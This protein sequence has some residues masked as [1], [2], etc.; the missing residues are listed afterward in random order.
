MFANTPSNSLSRLLLPYINDRKT[1]YGQNLSVGRTG[2]NGTDRK[3]VVIEFSSPNLGVYFHDGDRHSWHLK[4]AIYGSFISN[5]YENMGWEVVRLNYLGDW[6]KEVANLILGW[7]KFGS[8]DLYQQN[9]VKHLADVYSQLKALIKPE[10]EAIQKAR[11]EGTATGL[12]EQGLIGER[13]D[14]CRRMEEGDQTILDLWTGFRTTSI[15]S[16]M[17][18]YARL[19]ISFDEYAGESQASQDVIAEVE[20]QLREKGLYEMEGSSWGIDFQKHGNLKLRG[21]PFTAMR[22]QHGLSTYLL[23]DVATV[24]DRMKKFGP[25]DKM[26]YV[27]SSDQESHFKKVFQTIRL[28]DPEMADKLEL[29]GIGRTGGLE[30]NLV[31]GDILDQAKETM[32]TDPDMV[33]LARRSEENLDILGATSLI[34]QELDKKHGAPS[35]VDTTQMLAP[36]DRN[37]RFLQMGYR[38]LSAEIKASN[39]TGQPLDN[40][41]FSL[42][43]E[44]VYE[45]VLRIMAQFPDAV[46]S[47]FK[48][49]DSAP[50]LN[51]LYRLV[52]AVNKIIEYV[53][54]DDQ[55][56]ADVGVE[57]KVDQ[58]P[59]QSAPDAGPLP[60]A[61]DGGSAAVTGDDALAIEPA[62]AAADGSVAAGGESPVALNGDAPPEAAPPADIAEATQSETGEAPAVTEAEVTVVEGDEA[63]AA[64][65]SGETAT[66]DAAVET[67][68]AQSTE[69]DSAVVTTGDDTVT[70]DDGQPAP[71]TNAIEPIGALDGEVATAATKDELPAAENEAPAAETEVEATEPAHAQE[72]LAAEADATEGPDTAAV[73][74]EEPAL[75]GGEEPE[76]QE[77]PGAPVVAGEAEPAAAAVGNGEAEPPPAPDEDLSPA[78]VDEVAP[79]VAEASGPSAT[80][81]GAVADAVEIAAT[82]A[83]AEPESTPE[84][85]VET[86]TAVVEPVD[87]SADGLPPGPGGGTDGCGEEEESEP[88]NPARVLAEAALY[89]AVRQVLENGMRLLGMVPISVAV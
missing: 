79:T 62:V 69:V 7:K 1:A 19:N 53:E 36:D 89:M 37:A 32:R 44:T 55:I 5:L 83:A 76:K 15:E 64:T 87:G 75:A 13:N 11:E 38:A 39:P 59:D 50:I 42:I 61:V 6:G 60:E 51:C 35:T 29:V 18:E 70:P 81:E 4:S 8:E 16:Y 67:E 88:E 49:R 78:E 34:A 43:D 2:E 3:K 9:A 73:G 41:D 24:L 20:S 28:L 30:K 23:R 54:E 57:K 17:K 65:G 63:V 10:E 14:M 52:T 85:V 86:P 46:H 48:T 68:V 12:E 40:V 66:E 22:D 58:L 74:A 77:E 26:I 27:A 47:A 71:L 84:V 33:K 82:T 80:N 31:L 25:V 45:D 72:S 21:N 56:A